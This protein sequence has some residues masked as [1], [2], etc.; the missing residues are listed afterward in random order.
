MKD[1]KKWPLNMAV[2]TSGDAVV[3]I[4]FAVDSSDFYVFFINALEAH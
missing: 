3:V 2:G 1:W 4:G